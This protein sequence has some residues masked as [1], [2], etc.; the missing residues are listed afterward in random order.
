MK[1]SYRKL[2]ESHSTH[3]HTLVMLDGVSV[4]YYMI[5]FIKK[6]WTF[7]SMDRRFSYFVCDTEKDIKSTLDRLISGEEVL[8][9]LHFG[10][11]ESFSLFV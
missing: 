10:M 9:S 1:L 7:I 8:L 11:K 3:A 6:D 2:K 4:G 5:G